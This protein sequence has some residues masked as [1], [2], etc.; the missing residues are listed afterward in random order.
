M[1]EIHGMRLRQAAISDVPLLRSWD[2]KPHVRAAIGNDDA[3]DWV[4][5]ISRRA[6][7]GEWLIAEKDERA[8]G[9]VQIIDPKKEVT[10]YWGDV[11]PGLRAVDIWIGW[12]KDLAQGHGTEIMRLVL[13]RCF[14]SADVK[15]V[16]LDP[17]ASNVR[18]QRFY[19]RLGFESVGQRFFGDDDCMVFRLEREKWR[20]TK[21]R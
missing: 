11:E 20:Q 13:E 3:V 6:D 12:E 15:A 14:A 17:L 7:W 2:S 10:N 8:I 16:L 4:A 9:V 18:A 19:K 5:E 21:K 1:R